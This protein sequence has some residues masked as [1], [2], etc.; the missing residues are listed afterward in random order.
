MRN[1]D[2][3]RMKEVEYD[4]GLLK[5]DVSVMFLMCFVQYKAVVEGKA[6]N[7]Y[8]AKLE[9]SLQKESVIGIYQ[10]MQNYVDT[11]ISSIKTGILKGMVL[12][13]YDY[14]DHMVDINN[15]VHKFIENYAVKKDF[16]SIE[17]RVN[18]IQ[19]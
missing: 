4:V 19:K 11:S 17:T 1:E 18:M 16:H 2:E 9:K 7:E 3:R 10:D 8:V 15:R 13:F 14:L 12:M 5:N 6:D